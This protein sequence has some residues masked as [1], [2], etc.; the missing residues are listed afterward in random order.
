MARNKPAAYKKRLG[1]CVK[2][3]QPLPV[4]IRMKTK[5]KVRENPARKHWRS[6]KL[7]RG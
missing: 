3:N 1:K 2:Q 4:W 5:M 7:K 6:S